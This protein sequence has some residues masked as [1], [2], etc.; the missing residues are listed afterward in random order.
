[1]NWKPLNET[2]FVRPDP[3]EMSYLIPDHLKKSMVELMTGVII[4]VGTGTLLE[5]GVRSPLQAN[6]GDRVLFGSQVGHKIKV[7]KEDLLLLAEANILAIEDADKDK[8]MKATF[9]LKEE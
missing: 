2:Y 1:M 6:V 3:I 9:T 5:S 8:V 4:A 7:D